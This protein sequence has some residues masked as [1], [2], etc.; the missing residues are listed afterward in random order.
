MAVATR[1]CRRSGPSTL[2]A[3][4]PCGCRPRLLFA[5]LVQGQRG[6][7]ELLTL[8]GSG[9]V[10]GHHRRLRRRMLCP[11]ELQEPGAVRPAT[12]MG[13]EPTTS[14]LTTRRSPAELRGRSSLAW[15]RTRNR[16]LNR[17]MLCRLSYRGLGQAVVHHSLGSDWTDPLPA[18]SRRSLRLAPRGSSTA[19]PRWVDPTLQE[20]AGVEGIEPSASRSRVGRTANR[21]APQWLQRFPA[22]V[23]MAGLEPATSGTQSRRAS[24]CATSRCFA[25]TALVPTR[26]LWPLFA[27][28][29]R[30]VEE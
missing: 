1:Q 15:T 2:F 7:W 3:T 18:A 19:S 29:G 11:V 6:Q 30:T 21:A 9:C 10:P 16:P 8:S 20:M 24:H 5:P 25:G 27:P 12:P 22:A 28:K 23:G 14:A 13:V 26:G 4:G 17:R